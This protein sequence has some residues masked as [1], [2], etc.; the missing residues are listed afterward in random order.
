[1]P[2]TIPKLMMAP[3]WKKTLDQ[4]IPKV[5]AQLLDNGTL[6]PGSDLQPRFQKDIGP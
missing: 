4:S 2:S 5:L 6:R 3:G 1:M